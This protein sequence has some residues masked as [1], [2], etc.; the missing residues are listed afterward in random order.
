VRTVEARVPLSGSDDGAHEQHTMGLFDFLK[1]KGSTGKTETDER[2][3]LRHAERVMDKRAMSPDR[4]ASIEFLCR[5]A[6]AE[7]WRALLP[8]FNFAVDPSIQDREEKNYIFESITGNPENAVDPV[9]DYL[10]SAASLTWPIKMLKSML[11]PEDFVGELIDYL[12]TFDTGYEK[13]A[14]RK[15]QII[16]ALEEESDPRIAEAV[17]PFL[18]DFSEDIRFHTVR[19]LVAQNAESVARDA[20]VKLLIDDQSARIR[21]TVVDGLAEKGWTIDPS[22]KDAVAKV[23]VTVPNGPFV[24]GGEGKIVRR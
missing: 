15:A 19:T 14:E 10:R 13:N 20:L 6:T 2:T 21:S 12:A 1:G 8:R 4:F 17:L 3:V 5:L 22:Q 18:E 11:E 7:A 9:R 24:V 16:A 23:L